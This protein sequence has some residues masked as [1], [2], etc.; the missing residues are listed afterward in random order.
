[1]IYRPKYFE[2][3]E[4]V[5][6]ALYDQY[7]G[8]EHLLWLLFDCH[9]LEAQDTL[10]ERYGPFVANDWWWG[11]V[12]HERGFRLFDTETGADLSQH[13][14]GRAIDS[15]P[16]KATVKE[17]RLDI[18]KKNIVPGLVTCVEADISWLHIDR[19]LPRFDGRVQVVHRRT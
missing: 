13:K 16:T 14:F 8:R 9:I 12:N 1:M 19:R 18:I 5:P 10:R 4:L 2:I 3:Y 6:K 7:A 11:G 15:K 17:V